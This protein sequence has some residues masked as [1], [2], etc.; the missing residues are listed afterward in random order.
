MPPLE[1]EKHPN[2]VGQYLAHK[3]MLEVPQMTHDVTEVIFSLCWCRI[4]SNHAVETGNR[5]V[6]RSPRQW[7][8]RLPLNPGECDKIHGVSFDHAI[9]GN[10]LFCIKVQRR[11]YN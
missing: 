10:P 5:G 1:I 8:I 11:W 7:L 4:S 9:W 6:S 2:G 3:P